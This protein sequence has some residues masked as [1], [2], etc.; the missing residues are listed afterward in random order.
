MPD[1]KLVCPYCEKILSEEH[2]ACCGEVGHGEW[3]SACEQCG[4][5]RI[6][7]S[8]VYQADDIEHNHPQPMCDDC[9]EGE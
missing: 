7:V 3:K 9:M 6:S 4:E 5:H 8:N 2:S 1:K